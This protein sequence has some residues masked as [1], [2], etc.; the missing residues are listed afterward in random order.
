MSPDEHI[1]VRE[2]CPS[3]GCWHITLR[4]DGRKGWGSVLEP[5]RRGPILWVC[6]DKRTGEITPYDDIKQLE[7]TNAPDEAVE[8]LRNAGYTFADRR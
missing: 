5:V 4:L 6:T 8:V 1:V 2:P 3:K 7:I